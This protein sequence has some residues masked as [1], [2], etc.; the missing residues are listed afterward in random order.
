MAILNPSALRTRGA[1][2]AERYRSEGRNLVL[3]YC[4]VTALLM[5]AERA[6]KEKRFSD[7]ERYL[8]ARDHRDAR[9]HHLMGQCRFQAG[10]YAA[11]KEHYHRCEESYDVRSLLEICYREL[12]D[13]R[14]AYFYAKKG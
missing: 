13:F 5:K 1:A 12:E 4:G 6:L 3:I 9:W 2:A 14:M 8:L 11:A 7:A 10:D